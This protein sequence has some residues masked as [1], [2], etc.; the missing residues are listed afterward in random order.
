ML[1]PLLPHGSCVAASGLIRGGCPGRR[2]DFFAMVE[3]MKQQAS[4]LARIQTT[5]NILVQHLDP[6]F[7]LGLPVAIKAAGDDEEPD[8][9]KALVVADPIGAGFTLSQ[10]A[11]AAGLG[12]PQSDVSILVRAFDLDKDGECAVTVRHGESRSMVNYHPRAV[13]RF[14][15]CMA[16]PPRTL[17]QNQRRALERAKARLSKTSG[18]P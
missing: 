17:S 7:K 16:S 12:L 15:K 3:A 1:H 2:F 9:A 14:R 11:L 13:E 6:K 18:A 10:A 5:L 8:L 4:A